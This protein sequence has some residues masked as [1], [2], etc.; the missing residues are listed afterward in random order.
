M[1]PLLAALL[2]V[3]FAAAQA[4]QPVSSRDLKTRIVLDVSRVDVLLTVTDKRGNFITDLKKEDFEVEDDSRPQQ[5]LGFNSRSDQPLR[6][7]VLID[8]SNS[9]RQRFR[10]IQEVAI[11]FVRSVVRPHLDQAM[12]VTFD[13]GVHPFGEMTDDVEKVAGTI[14]GLYVGGVTTLYDA[15]HFASLERLV[16]DEPL[17]DYRRAIVVLSDGEDNESRV[18]RDQALEA[19]LRTDV[20]VYAISSSADTIESH[21]DKVLKYFASETGGVSLFPFKIEDLGKSFQQLANEL[22]HQYN[23]YYRPE[24]LKSDGRFHP[25]SIRVKGRKDYIVRAR[26][27]YY[28][29]KP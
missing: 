16:A 15:I 21:G 28:A 23:V 13:A 17:H 9:I 25:I 18:T 7:A 22:R 2:T 8:T 20:V 19:A 1:K 14:R 4:Q 27:G 3:G 6:L 24:P 26:K 29:P 5:V 12:V 11:E 10:F